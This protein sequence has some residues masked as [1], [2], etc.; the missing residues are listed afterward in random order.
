MSRRVL[1]VLLL[2][3]FLDSAAFGL[4]YP[5]LSS[6]L[7]DPKWHFVAPQTS[8]SIRGLWLGVLLS[9]SP[10]TQMIF[11]PF[12]GNLSDKIGRRPVI[13]GCL[14]IGT[15]A[16]LLAAFSLFWESL[17]GFVLARII[18]GVY[19][20]SYAAL[21]ACIAD[22]S[23]ATE[24]GR[25]FSLMGTAFGLGFSIG[26]LLG[27]VLAGQ[28]VLWDEWLP[29]PF[30]VA[31]ALVFLN[32]I[33]IYAW[34]PETKSAESQA[35]PP[36][37][38]ASIARDIFSIDA[39]LAAMLL[40]TFLFC[41][42]WSF[43]IDLIPVFWVAHFHMTTSQVGM[44]FAFGAVWYVISCGFLVSRLLR[45]WQPRKVFAMASFV[46]SSSI[47]AVLVLNSP[48]AFWGL[49]AVQHTSAACLFPVAATIISDMALPDNRG[50][51][52]GLHG[53]AECLGVGIA[54]VISG[55]FLGIHLLMP[56]VIGG[57]TVLIASLMVS[58]LG[59]RLAAPSQSL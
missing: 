16:W 54:P 27:G 42:G 8:E 45:R 14:C 39:G 4:V 48:E 26:P 22:L 23:D 12:I 47:W 52:M 36:Q 25:G 53:S 17:Y 58:R 3:A 40:A 55:P 5:L 20:A 24:R 43:Y 2:V 32:A 15:M 46:L 56:V 1:F 31:S 18:M 41:F 35:S 37:S 57:L 51:V 33:W 11:S 10:I 50:K 29:R 38:L 13:L 28:T 49:F 21:N 44:Y 19:V 34:L 30:L 9:V 6:L 59:K 7:F